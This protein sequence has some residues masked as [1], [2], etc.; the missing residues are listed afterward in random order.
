MRSTLL[1]AVSIAMALSY[2]AGSA[3]AEDSPP[4]KPACNEKTRGKL[5]PKRAGRHS[6]VSPIEMCAMHLWR[7]RWEQLTVDVSQL[8]EESAAP[9]KAPAVYPSGPVK[10]IARRGAPTLK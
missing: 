7:Y 2:F 4:A 5:W 8:R 3:Y 6:A 1:L 10:E 9:K